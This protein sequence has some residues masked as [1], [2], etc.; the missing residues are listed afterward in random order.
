VD[1]VKRAALEVT[2]KYL[3]EGPTEDELT[4]AKK[5]IAASEIFAR[6]NQMGMANWYGSLMIAGESVEEIE[7]WD[8]R[9]TA[10]TVEQVNAALRKYMT[11]V[12][13]IDA[14]LMPEK[15]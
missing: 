13:H 14:V 1:D 11:G 3:K 15:E 10:V 9:I 12:N 5:R 8:E 2:E 6:D 4:R 7:T